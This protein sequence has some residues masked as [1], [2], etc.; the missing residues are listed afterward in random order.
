[1]ERQ[2]LPDR[3]DAAV[4][5]GRIG[6]HGAFGKSFACLIDGIVFAS[7]GI[8]RFRDARYLYPGRRGRPAGSNVM[9]RLF[10][11]RTRCRTDPGRQARAAVRGKHEAVLRAGNDIAHAPCRS[12]RER[13]VLRS[14]ESR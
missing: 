2:A 7:G 1:M 13:F 6:I 3:E 4:S 10:V 12:D 14:R 11:M 9:V 5:K 8:A